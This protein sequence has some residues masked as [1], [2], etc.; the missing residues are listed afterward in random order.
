MSRISATPFVY[1][2]N[3]VSCVIIA[4]GGSAGFKF[5]PRPSDKS[6]GLLYFNT[7]PDQNWVYIGLASRKS[8]ERLEGLHPYI[9]FPIVE[10]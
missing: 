10:E 4:S 2:D 5:V 8:I 3:L 1:L 9:K 7:R 6:H